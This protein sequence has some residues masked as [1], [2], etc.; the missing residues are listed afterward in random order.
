MN[1]IKPAP[2][3]KVLTLRA[4]P[5]RAFEVFTRSAGAWWP[6]SHTIGQAP[7][8]DVVLE[9]AAGGRWYGLGEDGSIDQWGKVLAWEPPHRLLLAWQ[10]NAEWRFDPE[11]VTEVEVRFEPVEVGVT[12]LVFEHRDLERFG[13]QAEKM[14]A[15]FDSPGGWAGI[16]QRFIEQAET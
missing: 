12:R 3:R 5:E 9:P 11:L 15:A 2:V 8:K 7:L 14:H 16:L 1:L 10:I 13:E 6:K 4:S